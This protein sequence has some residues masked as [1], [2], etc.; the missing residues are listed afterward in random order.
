MIATP[1]KQVTHRGQKVTTLEL[2]QIRYLVI[3]GLCAIEIAKRVNVSYPT[4]VRTIKENFPKLSPLLSRNGKSKRTLHHIKDGR[5]MYRRY[6]KDYCENCGT[7][8]GRLEIHHKKPAQYRGNWTITKGD[9]SKEN[10]ITLCNS[11]HQK[12]HYRKLG[13]K[14]LVKKDPKTGRFLKTKGESNS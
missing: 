7:K 8:E 12:E 4:I 14:M 2:N 3:R 10:L 5:A 6:K 9:H 11:C 13:R 1:Y